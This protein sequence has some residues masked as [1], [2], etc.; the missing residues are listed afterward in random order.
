MDENET[1]RVVFKRVAVRKSP[2]VTAEIVGAET[3]GA[4]V[5]G[6]LSRV[7]GKLWVHRSDGPGWML[8]DGTSL[9]LGKLLEAVPAMRM[10]SWSYA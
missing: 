10:A 4:T 1:F 7:Q 5:T 2:S 8:L 3:K 6:K 9:G